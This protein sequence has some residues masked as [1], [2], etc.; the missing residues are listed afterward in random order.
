MSL[1][2]LALRH[3]PTGWNRDGLIQGR[4]DVPLSPEGR[5]VAAAWRLPA[6]WKGARCLASPLARAMETA[7]ILG[8]DPQPQ[9]ALI[10][11][12]WGDFEGHTLAALRERHGASMAE[13]ETRGLDFLP[14]GGE[15]PRM[16]RERLA[17]FLPT[18]AAEGSAVVLVTHRGVL[19]ALY[20]LATGW[21]MKTDPPERLRDACAHQYELDPDGAVGMV[22]L[23]IPLTEAS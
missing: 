12:H 2:L 18:L 11:M 17:R 10:E 13:N 20:S 7:R 5:A 6:G 16:V 23:N 22:Q 3:A 8:L 9:P 15:S 4:R 14:D 19:R 21:E 1:S